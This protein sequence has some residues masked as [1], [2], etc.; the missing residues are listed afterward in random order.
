[1]VVDDIEEQRQIASA[2]LQRLGYRVATAAS[3]E[4]A[5]Q[6]TA[7]KRYDLLLL[8][9]I[10]DPG[11]D[12]LDTYLRILESR[13]HLPAILASGFSK[14]ERVRQALNR[15]ASAYLRKPY[16][17][18]T[19]EHAVRKALAGAQRMVGGASATP[20]NRPTLSPPLD[21]CTRA[22]SPRPS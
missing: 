1:L 7:A 9:M 2:I 12:G 20:S 4:E 22:S 11:M 6:K 21:G 18:D 19:L 3:G 14:N 16:T 13:P 5:I 17:L 10:M 15:G 8:D